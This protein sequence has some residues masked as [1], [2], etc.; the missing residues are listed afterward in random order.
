MDVKSKWLDKIN[1]LGENNLD[2]E[3]LKKQ[4]LSNI[5]VIVDIVSKGN[6]SEI[7][8]NKDGILILEA[9]RKKVNINLE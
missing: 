8:K 6:T 3:V 9:S 7:K 2:R 1:I 5:D 4:L